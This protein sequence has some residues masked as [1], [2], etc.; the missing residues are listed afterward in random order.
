MCDISSSSAAAHVSSQ[1]RV[2]PHQP[3]RV[4]PRLRHLLRCRPQHAMC[5]ENSCQ[6]LC[7]FTSAA[8]YQTISS[9]IRVPDARC[10]PRLVTADIR[11]CCA[12]G[13]TGL[14]V[15]PPAVGTRR[16]CSID[17]RPA[18]FRS[19]HRHTRQFPLVETV[20]YKLETIVYRSLNCMAPHYLAADL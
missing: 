13:L 4:S 12:G 2:R 11:Q 16:C 5:K 17:R 7:H 19:H 10:R 14:P 18:T 1:D 20:Q 8:Q 15:Q 9:N 6:L 3:V